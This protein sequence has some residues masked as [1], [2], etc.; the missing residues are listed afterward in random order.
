MTDRE[1]FLA[2]FGRRAEAE[3]FSPGRVNLIGEHTDYNGGLVLPLAIGLGTRLIVARRGDRLI[4]IH[5]EALD[6]TVTLSPETLARGPAGH[7]RD[8]PLGVLSAFP[9]GWPA[10]GLD[11]LLRSDLPAGRGL[12][13]SAS[14]NLG[15]AGLVTPSPLQSRLAPTFPLIHLPPQQGIQRKLRDGSLR[16]II[17][18][19]QG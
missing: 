10:T 19:R 13:S 16:S 1:A 17:R 8:H 4:R 6:E 15:F 18:K 12:S 3:F 14:L 7:W 2:R 5:S 9:G 11:L